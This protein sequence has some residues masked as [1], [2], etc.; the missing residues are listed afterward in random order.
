MQ[1][2][3]KNDSVILLN[4]KNKNELGLQ[5]KEESGDE[6]SSPE[7]WDEER[8][9]ESGDETSAPELWD[10][11]WRE[12]SRGEERTDRFGEELSE[13]HEKM[14]IVYDLETME[15][16]LWDS[17]FDSICLP[18]DFWLDASSEERMLS[19]AHEICSHGKKAFLSLPELFRPCGK[20]DGGKEDGGRK[21]SEKKGNME[22]EYRKAH[23]YEK[24][25][26]ICLWP[27]WSGIYVNNLGEAEFMREL[28]SP[29]LAPIYGTASFYHWNHRA[30]EATHALFNLAAVELPY[31]LSQEECVDMIQAEMY[32]PEKILA[33]KGGMAEDREEAVA[34]VGNTA[35]DRE[36]TV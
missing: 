1:F 30:I 14:A 34:D 13:R 29:D 10:E 20:K 27:C 19:A 4:S 8:R 7:L 21:D 35:E 6:T 22:K 36:E 2:P 18:C 5:K 17:F 16:C 12:G 11:T 24:I 3:V 26:R 23:G 31:E 32:L 28:G 15:H 33:D 9:G 25:R